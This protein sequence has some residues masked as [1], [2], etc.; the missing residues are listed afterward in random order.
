MA[1]GAVPAASGQSP[2]C[3][4]RSCNSINHHKS[5]MPNI[6][7]AKSYPKMTLRFRPCG[8]LPRWEVK[9]MFSD[10]VTCPYC[11]ATVRPANMRR[12]QASQTCKVAQE[13]STIP[14][15]WQ[16]I[17]WAAHG[18]FY[19]LKAPQNMPALTY[20]CMKDFAFSY[21]RPGW[22]HRGRVRKALYIDPRL[23]AILLSPCLSDDEKRACL[24]LRPDTPQFQAAYVCA[25]LG[26]NTD[27]S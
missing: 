16:R 23:R 18:V 21:T 3:V 7:H 11:N 5:P 13:R 27:E 17:G 15:T 2:T 4:P 12:H 6:R 10:Y 22:G 26:P 14:P 8:L 25:V 24:D 20:P 1:V 19:R 9:P